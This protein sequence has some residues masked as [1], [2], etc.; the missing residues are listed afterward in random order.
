MP[1]AAQPVAEV[2]TDLAT[3]LRI[4]DITWPRNDDYDFV[5][6]GGWPGRVAVITSRTTGQTSS[7]CLKAN[8]AT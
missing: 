3:T 5:R 2:L 4:T 1:I 7:A 8:A 6:N